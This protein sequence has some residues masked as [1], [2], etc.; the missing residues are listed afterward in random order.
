MR[1][2]C[3]LALIAAPAFAEGE[4][5]GDFDYY[6]LSLSW[7][8]SFCAI[9]G[10]A[11][12]E[13][14]C[15]PRHDFSFTLHG[16]WPQNETGWPSYCRSRERDPSRTE[17]NAM[18]DIMGSGGLAW[19]QWKKHGRC[20]GLSAREYF[21][22]SR[23]AYSRINIP[24]VLANLNR[25]VRLPASVVEDAFEEENPGLTAPMITITCGDGRIREARI[26]LTRDLEYRAC[27]VDTARDCRM[28]DALMEAVR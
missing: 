9:E 14:Q 1:W 8:P 19:H 22:A 25:D 17:T 24:D 27:G 13:D 6:V 4:K 7:S 18:R 28:Q 15:D 26:C 12:N 23:N 21:E 10:D 16:L 20:S 3:L 2:L 11:R 5:P